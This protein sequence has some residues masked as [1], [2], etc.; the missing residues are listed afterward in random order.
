MGDVIDIR[1]ALVKRRARQVTAEIALTQDELIRQDILTVLYYEPGTTV[2]DLAESLWED[3]NQ[4]GDG[5]V[6][7]ILKQMTKEGLVS[8]HNGRWF[9]SADVVEAL[10]KEFDDR[11]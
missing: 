3:F 10:E 5:Q 9:L 7:E 1:S 8:H 11:G 4:A 6:R 2:R